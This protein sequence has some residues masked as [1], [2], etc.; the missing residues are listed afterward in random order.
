MHLAFIALIVIVSIAGIL[1]ITANDIQTKMSLNDAMDDSRKI[2][3]VRQEETLKAYINED[4][5]IGIMNIGFNDA[6]VMMYGMHGDFG[7]SNIIFTSE[8][9]ESILSSLSENIIM[10]IS[11]APKL[12]PGEEI[13]IVPPVGITLNENSGGYIVSDLARKYPLENKMQMISTNNETDSGDGQ[14]VINGMGIQKRIIK[15]DILGT[16]IFGTDDIGETSA[17]LPYQT[18]SNDVN[19][20]AVIEN[21]D[22]KNT[23]AISDF[24]KLYEFSGTSL[25]DVTPSVPNILG[26]STSRDMYGTTDI[27]IDAEGIHVSGTGMRIIKMNSMDGVD[28]IYRVTVPS[29]ASVELV[30]SPNDFMSN[31]ITTSN[32]INFELFSNPI[33]TS[34]VTG[35]VYISHTAPGSRI[36]PCNAEWKSDVM[37]YWTCSPGKKWNTYGR[38][39]GGSSTSVSNVFVN[40]LAQTTVNLSYCLIAQ[41]GKSS[42]PWVAT[43]GAGCGSTTPTISSGTSNGYVTISGASFTSGNPQA[44][45]GSGTLTISSIKPYTSL[46]LATANI[47]QNYQMPVGDLYLMVEPNGG[48]V[49]IK[50][51]A[52]TSITS[53]V[54]NISSIDTGVPYDISQNG[55]VIASGVT[56]ST[57]T[58]VLNSIDGIDLQSMA[59]LNLYPD[60]L[61]Y[62]G[63]ISS[64]IFDTINDKMIHTSTFPP[65]IKTIFAW[66]QVPIVGN[67]EITDVTLDDTLQLDLNGNYTDGFIHIPVIPNYNKVSMQVNDLDFSFL[68]Y[69]VLDTPD[70]IITD[71]VSST[72]SLSDS[73]NITSEKVGTYAFAIATGDGNLSAKI[74]LTVSGSSSLAHVYELEY[75]GLGT[76]SCYS[77]A[78]HSNYVPCSNANPWIGYSATTDV[79][80][81]SQSNQVEIHVNGEYRDTVTLAV[82]TLPIFTNID[83]TSDVNTSSRSFFDSYGGNSGAVSF[84]WPST[85]Q[86]GGGYTFPSSVSSKT[87]SVSVEPGD[88]VEFFIMSEISESGLSTYS[89]PAGF[90]VV[91]DYYVGRSTVTINDASI[92]MS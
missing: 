16:M 77:L 34:G 90:S 58:I 10:P 8:S 89:P 9:E 20:A 85:F 26:Y 76:F 62:E 91:N 40:D 23:F 48:T 19:F 6:S 87:F 1:S 15:N 2:D 13:T 68:Y 64:L 3:L 7:D 75:D 46:L 24:W 52:D 55:S 27:S 92:L 17:I 65:S 35:K 47:A 83:G 70:I 28:I 4:G 82:T 30:E 88:F 81:K 32:G 50:G 18:I 45:I 37:Y 79:I 41:S 51:E 71:S 80:S 43:Y 73:D 14:A 31:T 29:E 49:T 33:G 22:T 56:S 5:T 39:F 78:S 11:D 74:D 38:T 21:S 44:G 86:L 53:N 42:P 25:V 36:L 63:E 61:A 60:S 66:V 12:K 57:G 84:S 69:N 72:R 67:V 54:V 59:L